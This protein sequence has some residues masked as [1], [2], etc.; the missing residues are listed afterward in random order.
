[1]YT[2][3]RADSRR[4]GGGIDESAQSGVC[5]F[6]EIPNA[7]KGIQADRTMDRVSDMAPSIILTEDGID[8]ADT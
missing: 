7:D 5:G 8:E 4:A 3:I 2:I 6:R 1:M